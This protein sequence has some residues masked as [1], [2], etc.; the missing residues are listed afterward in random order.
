VET[1]A[2]GTFAVLFGVGFAVLMRSFEAK[3]LPVVAT[4]LRRL[5]GLAA[6]GVV[7]EAVLGFT[8]LLEYAIWAV[9]LLF[10]RRLSSRTLL[11]LALLA[12]TS[13]PLLQ[14]GLASRRS[15]RPASSSDEA[16]IAAV[17]TPRERLD[18]ARR[19]SPFGELVRIRIEVMKDKYT[20]PRTWMP[21]VN[22]ALFIV[23]M[24]AFRR[25]IFDDPRRHVRTIL[26]WIAFGFV[27][28]A[29]WWLMFAFGPS[30]RDPWIRGA[31]WGFGLIRD[32]WLTFTYMGALILLLAYRPAWTGRL[33]AVGVAGRMALTNYMLQIAALDWLSSGYGA[34]LHVR[35][36]LSIAFSFVLFGALAAFSHWWLARFRFGPAEWI[37]RCFTYLRWQPLSRRPAQRATPEAA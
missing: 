32:Q 1:K 21:G 9:P 4:Y 13:G 22:L 33:A 15:A 12:V 19:T 14:A 24:L 16:S 18:E 8:V 6:F 3:G 36:I 27:A 5:L 29:A 10:M 26:A 35:P 30:F 28:W 11:V 34:A 7:A 17:A 20:S 31:A 23:G 37:W 2:W 25:G